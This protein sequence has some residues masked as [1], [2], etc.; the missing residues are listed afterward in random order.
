MIAGVEEE[1]ILGKDFLRANRCYWN[2]EQN[3]LEIDGNELKCRVPLLKDIPAVDVKAVK[4]YTIPA[5]TEMI[6]EGTL[7]GAEK[8]LTTGM[9]TGKAKFIKKKTTRSGSYPCKTVLWHSTST[10]N[11]PQHKEEICGNQ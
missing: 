5:Q 9:I 4:S 10:C 8:T 6:I 11:E 1:G 3:T 7:I 2:W